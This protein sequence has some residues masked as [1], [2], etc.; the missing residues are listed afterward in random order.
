MDVGEKCAITKRKKGYMEEVEKSAVHEVAPQ[1]ESHVEPV[2]EA[3]KETQEAS[4]S[5]TDEDRQERNWKAT[6][7]RQKELERELRLQKDMNEKLLQMASQQAPKQEI[8][9]LDSISDDEFIPKGKVSK[10]IRREAHKIADDLVKE[11]TEKLIQQ[12][13]QSQFLDRLKRQYSDFDDVVNADT[14]SL[15]EESEPELAQTIADSKDPYKI[16]VQSYK[17]IKALK[18]AER[19]PEKRHAKEVEKKLEKNEKTVQSPL[20]YEK[21]PMAQAFKVTAAEKKAL[22]EEMMGFASQSGFSY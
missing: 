9:E 20:A 5:R 11:K 19:A 3:P 18:I 22:Y 6:R 2:T 12:Q 4:K 10:L 1:T 16:G 7:E 13:N 14:L 17:Y 8:D 15:L 21:R